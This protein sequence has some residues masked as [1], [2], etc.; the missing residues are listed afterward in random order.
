MY[1]FES[2]SFVLNCQIESIVKQVLE[3]EVLIVY[4]FESESLMWNYQIVSINKG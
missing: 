1:D 4:N 3:V 2:K